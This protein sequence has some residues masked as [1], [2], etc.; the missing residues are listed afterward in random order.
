MITY[1]YTHTYLHT[2]IHTYFGMIA[3]VYQQT[4]IA[5]CILSFCKYEYIMCVF[6]FMNMLI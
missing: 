3:F 2:N 6:V 4:F 5:K 1:T